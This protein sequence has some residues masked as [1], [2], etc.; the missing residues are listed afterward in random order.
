[1]DT[2]EIDRILRTC[3]K[4]YVPRIRHSSPSCASA[5]K[6]FSSTS[7]KYDPSRSPTPIYLGVLAFDQFPF[8]KLL[9][10]PES[11]SML[12]PLFFVLNTDPS[13]EPGTHWLA[14]FFDRHSNTSEFFDSYGHDPT[15]YQLTFPANIHVVSNS[16]QLQSDNSTVCGQYCVFYLYFRLYRMTTLPR[17]CNQLFTSFASRKSRDRFVSN[18]VRKLSKSNFSRK[19]RS[20]FNTS[21]SLGFGNHEQLVRDSHQNAVPSPYLKAGSNSACACT[22]DSP[23][24]SILDRSELSLCQCCKSRSTSKDFG[25]SYLSTIPSLFDY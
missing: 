18:F 15:F 22:N 2:N 25:D 21:P 6:I 19:G 5:N 14:C 1:M 20:R 12:A 23:S 11:S 3:L 9:H 7:T 4:S 24:A 17:I 13:T 16:L 10:T 8:D